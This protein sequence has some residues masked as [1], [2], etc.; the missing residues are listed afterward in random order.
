MGAAGGGALV[1][2]M[3]LMEK[4]QQ[5]EG[6]AREGGE[7]ACEGRGRGEREKA[8]VGFQPP[9]SA[10]R[11]LSCARRSH[12][13]AGKRRLL[14]FRVSVIS[15]VAGF[16]S[17]PSCPERARTEATRTDHDHNHS[18]HICRSTPASVRPHNAN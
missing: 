9:S 18:L 4:K 13:I 8:G 5:T 2:M 10:L 16:C 1:M 17:P 3:T 11:R 7:E 14:S 12:A 15:L 6:R